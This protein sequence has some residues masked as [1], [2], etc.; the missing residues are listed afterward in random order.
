MLAHGVS[1]S[2][3]L[4]GAAAIQEAKVKAAEPFR[5]SI[6]PSAPPCA[7]GHTDRP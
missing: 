2:G 3:S 6:K 4:P 1:A 7:L 5:A